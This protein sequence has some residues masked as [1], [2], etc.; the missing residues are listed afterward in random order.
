MSD[1]DLVFAFKIPG[2][3]TATSRTD[4]TVYDPT[5]ENP[6]DVQDA[7]RKMDEA[8]DALPKSID[9]HEYRDSES[10]VRYDWQSL[11]RADMTPTRLDPVRPDEFDDVS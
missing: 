8:R 11:V 10:W 2:E 7:H 9:E 6:Y 1:A 4:A 3:R 5:K